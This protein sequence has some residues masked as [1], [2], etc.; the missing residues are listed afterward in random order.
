MAL[1]PPLLGIYAPHRIS[2][3]REGCENNLMEL[4]LASCVHIKEECSRTTTMSVAGVNKVYRR[5]RRKEKRLPSQAVSIKLT[6]RD[7]FIDN[8]THDAL[9]DNWMT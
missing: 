2:G 1:E 3:C 7:A 4:R 8:H 9:F 6:A 5:R